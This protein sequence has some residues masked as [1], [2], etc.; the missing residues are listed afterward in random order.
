VTSKAPK[1]AVLPDGADPIQE[2]NWSWLVPDEAVES[3]EQWRERAHIEWL[4]IVAAMRQ[5]GT[6]GPE[7]RHQVQRLVLSYIR[8]DQAAAKAF[9][10]GMVVG[11]PRTGVPMMSLWRV[12]MRAADSD[13]QAGERELC[14]S[15]RRRA[16]AGRVKRVE[17]PGRASDAYLT[18]HS[19]DSGPF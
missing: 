9:A 8:F 15:P 4:S 12:E 19:P 13:A 3:N 17:T 5:A 1:L 11:A 10:A 18:R 7:N 2:P 6:L 14:L 16:G